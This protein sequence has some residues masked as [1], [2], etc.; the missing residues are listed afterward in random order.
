MSKN[1]E[2][3]PV[4]R[5]TLEVDWRGNILPSSWYQHIRFENGKTDAIACLILAD[6][7]YWYRPS[8]I[9]SEAT[10]QVMRYERKFKLDKLQR[11]YQELAKLLGI[12]KR[13]ATDACK[14]LQKLGLLTIEQRTITMD[15]GTMTGVTYL[16]PV[17]DKVK[18]ITNA[19]PEGVLRSNVGGGTLERKDTDTTTMTN[20]IGASVTALAQNLTASPRQQLSHAQMFAIV[21]AVT[22]IDAKIKRNGALIGKTVKQLLAAGYTPGEVDRYYRAGGWWYNQDWRGKLNHPPT[23]V[24]IEATIGLAREQL[25]PELPQDTSMFDGWRT[26]EGG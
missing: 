7:V 20:I 12:T 24:Q 5:A 11:S 18:A 23:L 3:T 2:M 16:E 21:Q 4:V 15:A 22:H 14:R 17:M 26:Q 10:G 19:P 9:R 13:Q 25:G 8:E 6:I 1:K